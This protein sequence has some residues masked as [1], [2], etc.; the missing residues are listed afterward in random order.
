MEAHSGNGL[1]QRNELLRQKL[2]TALAESE[3][4]AEN[5]LSEQLRMV[6]SAF[7]PRL[8]N[9]AFNENDVDGMRTAIRRTHDVSPMPDDCTH[10]RYAPNAIAS[11]LAMAGLGFGPENVADEFRQELE[12]FYSAVLDAG[13]P[14]VSPATR[15][16][17]VLDWSRL[18]SEKL[19]A[20]DKEVQRAAVNELLRHLRLAPYREIGAKILGTIPDDAFARL[21]RPAQRQLID[22]LFAPLD[23]GSRLVSIRRLAEECNGFGKLSACIERFGK[24]LKQ[25]DEGASNMLFPDG[26]TDNVESHAD[27][28][29]T[30]APEDRTAIRESLLMAVLQ[31]RHQGLGVRMASWAP[32]ICHDEK[33]ASRLAEV[34]RALEAAQNASGPL[35][36]AQ[37]Q[38][39]SE[40]L[41][42]LPMP[43]MPVM[44]Q[45]FEKFIRQRQ[46]PKS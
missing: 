40:Q 21:E 39:L 3:P 12:S 25:A 14:G 45:Y 34:S 35:P 36:D 41:R 27:E 44:R 43:Y 28:P 17:I 1:E 18:Q 6:G 20:D 22:A 19:R 15:A 2:K 38:A 16:H 10:A 32:W 26:L 30:V 42:T 7:A 46:D 29:R 8:P 37:Y 23:V 13:L 4:L 5:L 24:D 9:D 11:L 31:E 33:S